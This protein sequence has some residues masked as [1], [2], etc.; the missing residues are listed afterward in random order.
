MRRP[1]RNWCGLLLVLACCIC[2]RKS[3]RNFYRIKCWQPWWIISTPS[4]S[5]LHTPQSACTALAKNLITKTSRPAINSVCL[6]LASGPMN[7][8]HWL[9]TPPPPLPKKRGRS[10]VRTAQFATLLLLASPLIPLLYPSSLFGQCKKLQ[11]HPYPY[12]DDVGS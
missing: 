8:P 10:R 5:I 2:P 6:C 7:M 4:H 11:A 9:R 3:R 12:A 1:K